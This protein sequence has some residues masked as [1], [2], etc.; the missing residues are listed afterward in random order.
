MSTKYVLEFT[1]VGLPKT[2]NSRQHWAEKMKHTR[3]WR[4]YS[5]MSARRNRPP[6]PL[7]K[8]KVTYTRHSF[9]S[10]DFDNLVASFKPIQD[11]LI[12]AKIIVNDS[13]DV[14]GQPSFVWVKAPRGS[15]AVTVRV[16]AV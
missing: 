11:G 8:A 4:D 9:T 15:G 2:P 3:L 5:C 13:F 1:L 12:D 10:P 6:R 14:I 7:T 16:E